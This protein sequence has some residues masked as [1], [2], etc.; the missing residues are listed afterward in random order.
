MRVLAPV[1]LRYAVRE[2]ELARVL[3]GELLDELALWARAHELGEEELRE[4]LADAID[5]AR[6]AA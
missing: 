3:L 2:R 4:L 1:E 6:E 5:R